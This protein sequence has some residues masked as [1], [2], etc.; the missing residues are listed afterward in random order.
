MMDH[1]SPRGFAK[2][3]ALSIASGSANVLHSGAWP[4]IFLC[5]VAAKGRQKRPSRRNIDM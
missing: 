4:V 5:K 2:D 1:V 3:D